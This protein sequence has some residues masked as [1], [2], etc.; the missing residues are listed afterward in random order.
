MS[1]QVT[2][3]SR[4]ARSLALMLGFGG[5][6]TTDAQAA[7]SHV[8]VLPQKHAGSGSDDVLV[9]METDRIYV[10]ERG[11][12]FQELILGDTTEAEYLRTL[13]KGTGGDIVT[14]PTGS[15]IVANGGGAADGAKPKDPGKDQSG[16]ASQPEDKQSAKKGKQVPAATKPTNGK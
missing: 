5:L 2:S 1:Q 11:G 6:L 15:I 9:R 7:K 3:W 12:A 14:V 16:N 8:E 4:L 13:L 10:S